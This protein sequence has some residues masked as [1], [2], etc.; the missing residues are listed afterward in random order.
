MFKNTEINVKKDDKRL[1]QAIKVLKYF[2][3]LD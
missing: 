3:S 1:L 2:A